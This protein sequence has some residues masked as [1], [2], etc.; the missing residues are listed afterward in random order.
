MRLEA[1]ER[2]TRRIGVWRCGDQRIEYGARSL[3]MGIVNVTPD[4]FFDGN[5]YVRHQSAIDHACRMLEAGAD[6]IDV[7]GES[8]RPGAERVSVEQQIE[9]VAPVIEGVRTRMGALL[10]V[11]TTRAEVARAALDAGAVIINDISACREDPAMAGLAQRT[12]A[13]LVLMH[14]RGTPL[15]MQLDPVY[16]DVVS[17]VLEFLKT[18]GQRVIDQGVE[19]SQICIDPGIGFGKTVEHNLLLLRD[20]RRFVDTP[21]PVLLGTSRKSFL[22]RVLGR[23]VEDRLWGSLATA[24]WAAQAGVAVI[25]VHDVPQTVDVVRVMSSIQRES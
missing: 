22:G 3:V 24:A 20:L 25:R 14:M 10:S 9:R 12:G 15:T 21:F 4:S 16:A 11:D 8:T 6:L 1:G 2:T 18:A 13:G 23:E 17:E 19:P 5:R 7:G